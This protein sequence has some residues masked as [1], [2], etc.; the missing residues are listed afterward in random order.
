VNPERGRSVALVGRAAAVILALAGGALTIYA[1]LLVYAGATFEGDSL[2]GPTVLYMVAVG[3]GLAALSC[4]G[5]ARVLWRWA[6][7]RRE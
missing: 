1:G 4:A 2:P 6:A 5:L 3:V 7:R